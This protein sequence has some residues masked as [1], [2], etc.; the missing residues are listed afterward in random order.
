MD[1]VR[2]VLVLTGTLMLAAAGFVPTASASSEWCT[3]AGGS[4]VCTFRCG[5]YPWGRLSAAA[6]GGDQGARIIGECR[7][8]E[9]TCA[10][11][12][13]AVCNAGPEDLQ[14]GFTGVCILTDLGGALDAFG[15][16]T[17]SVDVNMC[18]HHS[19]HAHTYGV[20][21]QAYAASGTASV[22]SP[23]AGTVV[24]RDSNLGDCNGDGLGLDF[25]GDHDVAA[26]GAFFGYGPWADE[27]TCNYGLH[28]HGA[29]ASVLDAVHGTAIHVLAGANDIAGPT[30]T[31]D[32]LTGRSTCETDGVIRPCTGSDISSCGPTD[33][34]DDCLSG[35]D[36][37]SRT[38]VPSLGG[39]TTCG[40]GSDGGYWVFLLN[41]VGE[42]GNVLASNPPTFGTITA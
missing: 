39:V 33:D 31:Q 7:D 34:A 2:F 14:D 9:V 16:C 36:P 22:S 10:A 32:P 26:G 24:V 11:G 35:H 42:E 23:W 18:L 37:V 41:Y 19:P 28:A 8:A 29:T 3:V 20:S 1:A 17:G 21:M 38:F 13:H 6:S 5:L 12:P 4:G 30:V 15:T 27:S 25:D 40:A